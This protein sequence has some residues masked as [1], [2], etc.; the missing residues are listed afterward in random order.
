MHPQSSADARTA[1]LSDSG[2]TVRQARVAGL[3]RPAVRVLAR[4]R[5][6]RPGGTL[7]ALLALYGCWGAATPAMKLMVATAPPLA[8]AGLMFVFGAVVLGVRARATG[9]PRPTGAQGRRAALAGAVM[10]VGGQGLVTVALTRMTTSLVAVFVATIPLWVALLSRLGAGPGPRRA[11]VA[12]VGLGFAG[13]VTVIA[14]A[15]RAAV[16][17]SPWAV[18]ACCVA[19]ALWAVGTL[20]Q[21]DREAMP[22]DTRT[23]N[24]IGLGCGGLALL[25]LAAAFG[26]LDPAAWSGVSAGSLGAGAAL[27]VLDSL[28]GFSLYTRLL[29]TA[30]TALVS[31]YA[32][33]VPLV[34]IVIGAAAFGDPLWLGAMLG[35]GVVIATI[36]LE[37]RSPQP[38][39]GRGRSV[40]PTPQ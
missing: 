2:A 30:P 32:Y 11:S 7:L 14:S 17:G 5:L 27:L 16:G 21:A 26:Q 35:G 37:I 23:A 40:W 36:V 9:A 8:S 33:V 19:P 39:S 20:L 25:P 6:R 1:E 10:L 29:R 38:S 22:A 34:A 15:P 24:A 12:R 18:L 31:T 4:L 13:I 28:A 3:T